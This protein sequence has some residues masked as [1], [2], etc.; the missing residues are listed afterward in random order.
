MVSVDI[1]RKVVIYGFEIIVCFILRTARTLMRRRNARC[2]VIELVMTR[3]HKGR[4]HEFL[5]LTSVLFNIYSSGISLIRIQRD[6]LQNVG[7]E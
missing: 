3:S 5:L 6:K 4:L 2:N 7:V 1:L